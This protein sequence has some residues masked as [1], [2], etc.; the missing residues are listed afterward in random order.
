M[1]RVLLGLLPRDSGEILWNG[2][3]VESPADF[4]VPP[5]AAYAAQL[6]RLFSDTLRSNILLGIKGDDTKL[7]AAVR[8]AV[9]EQD[10]DE[11]E[12]GYDTKVGPKGVKLS[13]GQMQRTAAARML[14][15]DP[16]L[17]IFDDLSSALEASVV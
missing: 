9:M 14:I 16:E 6:P 10:L 17:L 2:R 11:L 8:R 15:R 12:D 5:R 13:G 1:L 4:M 3:A 7:D